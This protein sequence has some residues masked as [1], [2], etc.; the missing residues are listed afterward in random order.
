MAQMLALG[1][2]CRVEKPCYRRKTSLVVG[3]TWTQVLADSIAI[4]ASG[5]DHSIY[6]LYIDNIETIMVFWQKPS[7]KSKY[8]RLEEKFIKERQEIRL[9]LADF[10]EE[11]V[12]VKW[13]E[14]NR[15]RCSIEDT[16]KRSN[17]VCFSWISVWCILNPCTCWCSN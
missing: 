5:L 3:G 15:G 14:L 8:E 11:T 7:A 9:K 16:I 10:M 4:A 12:F 6:F 1:F 2:D 13:M 17:H